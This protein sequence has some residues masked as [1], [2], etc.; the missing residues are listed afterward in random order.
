MTNAIETILADINKAEDDASKASTT[1]QRSRE[2]LVRRF[3]PVQVGDIEAWDVDGTERKVRVFNV[4]VASS[5]RHGHKF[6]ATADVL[7][8]DGVET[9]NRVSCEWE[10][11]LDMPERGAEPKSGRKGAGKVLAKSVPKPGRGARK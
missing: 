5:G 6:V 4:Q 10:I 3:A 1:L 11:E 9:T 7:T 2:E 8:D